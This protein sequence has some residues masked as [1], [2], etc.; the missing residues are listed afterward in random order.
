MDQETVTEQTS[1]ATSFDFGKALSER[2]KA[3][4]A[5]DKAI[6]DKEA[7]IA[8]L[9]EQL[10]SAKP[11]GEL[12]TSQEKSSVSNAPS[13]YEDRLA[14]LEKMI[15]SI[16]INFFDSHFGTRQLAND[17]E[18]INWAK[19]EK[20][21]PLDPRSPTIEQVLVQA[22]E[23]ND[24]VLAESILNAFNQKHRSSQSVMPNF[25]AKPTQTVEQKKA[26]AKLQEL[27]VE[28][29]KAMGAGD[30]KKANQLTDEIK[31]LNRV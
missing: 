6:A 18:F 7:E 30:F 5:R 16:G 25:S 28:R 31:A 23:A 4:A 8:Q 29:E 21:A 27:R 26:E 11:V 24:S 13:P 15:S 3:L 1:Q 20:Y 9:R 17:E 10:N 22:R 14:N 12:S 19:T 2:D